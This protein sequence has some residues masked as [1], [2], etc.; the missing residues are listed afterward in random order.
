LQREKLQPRIVKGFPLFMDTVKEEEVKPSSFRKYKP[1]PK[2]KLEAL[3][4]SEEY[5]PSNFHELLGKYRIEVKGIFPKGTFPDSSVYPAEKEVFDTAF[6]LYLTGWLKVR[7]KFIIGHLQGDTYALSYFRRWLEEKH[8]SSSAGKI[9][10]VRIWEGN[11]G[12]ER[13]LFR[14]NLKCLKDMRLYARRKRHLLTTLQSTE[15]RE[16]QEFSNKKYDEE[17][18]RLNSRIIPGY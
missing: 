12:L 3:R 5:N 13:P 1:I 17:Q 14:N 8:M 2:P 16:L 11:L 7:E 10:W 15:A 4:D 18:T 9:D 6:G